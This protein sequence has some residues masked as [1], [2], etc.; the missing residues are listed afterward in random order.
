MIF[1]DPDIIEVY[2][3]AKALMAYSELP[4][5]ERGSLTEYFIQ[6][7]KDNNENINMNDIEAVQIV[8]DPNIAV[9]GI[10]RFTDAKIRDSKVAS[11]M[12]AALYGRMLGQDRVISDGI[13]LTNPYTE[14]N[15]LLLI[16]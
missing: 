1:S 12:L 11:N 14:N 8:V 2:P 15:K 7:S 16:D 3:L 10:P 13:E 6:W 4:E 5:T 9:N